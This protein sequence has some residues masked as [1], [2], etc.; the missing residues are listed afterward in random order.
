MRLMTTS[1][2]GCLIAAAVLITSGCSGQPT[3]QPAASADDRVKTLAD[4][5]LEGWFTRNPDQGT[6]YGVPGRHHDQLPDNSLTALA[7]WQRKE[8]AWLQEAAAIDPA[9]IQSG[10]LKGTYAIVREAIEGAIDTRLCRFELW[11]ASQM[12]G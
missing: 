12:T 4:A 5:Y 9:A 10:P 1:V 2:G 11:P 8:D 6:F 7:D 3:R